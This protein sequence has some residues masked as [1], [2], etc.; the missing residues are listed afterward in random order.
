[1]R[2]RTLLLELD[3]AVLVDIVDPVLEYAAYKGGGDYTATPVPDDALRLSVA[4]PGGRER[5]AFVPA[6]L[7]AIREAARDG[8]DVIWHSRWLTTPGVL[9]ALAD[10]LGL[11][12]AVRFPADDELA[13]T[14][15]AEGL[16]SDLPRFWD[17]WRTRTIVDRVRRLPAGHELVTAD[18]AVDLSALRLADGVRRRAG[19]PTALVGSIRTWREWGLD[20][21]ALRSWAPDRPRLPAWHRRPES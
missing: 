11:S 16:R 8:V 18:V 5:D 4:D 20:D 2:A 1:M 12:G 6:V 7:D 17:D 10:D 3:T 19:N 13:A 14:P 9:R 15:T 21:G